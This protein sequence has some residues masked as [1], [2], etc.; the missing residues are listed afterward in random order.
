MISRTLRDC[1]LDFNSM[2][3]TVSTLCACVQEELIDKLLKKLDLLK[4]ERKGLQEEIVDNEALGKRVGGLCGLECL[5]HG[6][7]GA[8]W[9]WLLCLLSVLFCLTVLEDKGSWK[10]ESGCRD[11]L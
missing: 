3:S 10:V 6:C 2:S 4:E 7:M 1:P 9:T 5:L 11:L 8:V